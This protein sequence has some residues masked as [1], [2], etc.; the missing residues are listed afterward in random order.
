MNRFW[1]CTFVIASFV[2]LAAPVLASTSVMRFY[3]ECE[4]LETGCRYPFPKLE[5]LDHLRVRA[6]PALTLAESD[7]QKSSFGIYNF[8][9]TVWTIELSESQKMKL[10]ELREMPER[11][12]L[13]VSVEDGMDY[14]A[15]SPKDIISSNQIRIPVA[16]TLLYDLPWVKRKAD[17]QIQIQRQRALYHQIAY[18]C[19]G[20]IFISGAIFFAFR[21]S[22]RSIRQ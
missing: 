8:R 16:N 6:V 13:V 19:F 2:C 10:E 3:L 5:K 1:A 12:K 21:K 15:I 9:D 14:V 20:I 11:M 18:S 17:E 22:K 7:I 4:D